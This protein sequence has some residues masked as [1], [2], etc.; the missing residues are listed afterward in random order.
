MRKLRGWVCFGLRGRLNN[1]ARTIRWSGSISRRESITFR[2]NGCM[3]VAEQPCSLVVMRPGEVG[4][5]VRCWAGDKTSLSLVLLIEGDRIACQYLHGS[6]FGNNPDVGHHPSY[7]HVLGQ[8]IDAPR[9][10]P[11]SLND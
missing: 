4:T 10:D 6:L 11:A 8:E 9:S 3:V 7:L 1:T 5:G 2:G